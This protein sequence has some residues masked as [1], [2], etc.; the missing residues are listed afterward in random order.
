M[1]NNPETQPKLNPQ[2]Q[3]QF[4]ELTAK[5]NDIDKLN[6][7]Q[8]N[9]NEQNEMLIALGRNQS[10][11]ADKDKKLNEIYNNISDGYQEIEQRKSVKDKY[12]ERLANILPASK[13]R[14]GETPSGPTPSK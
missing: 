9:A 2:Q 1:E 14:T 7:E 5:I 3:K 12:V 6:R 4:N 11:S 8:K 10:Y 13:P